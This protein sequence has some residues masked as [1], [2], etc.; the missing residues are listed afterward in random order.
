MLKG[1]RELASV[2]VFVLWSEAGST[3]W[4][5]EES[6]LGRKD[7]VKQRQGSQIAWRYKINYLVFLKPKL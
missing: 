3:E 4:K 5:R 7:G 6:I 2:W 1:G